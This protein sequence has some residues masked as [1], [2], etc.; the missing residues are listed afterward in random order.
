MTYVKACNVDSTFQEASDSLGHKSSQ[1]GIG[2]EIQRSSVFI[3]KL[4]PKKMGCVPKGQV[5]TVAIKKEENRD[6]RGTCAKF[7][8]ND[9]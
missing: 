4:H 8:W 7:D 5:R 6:D 2:H 1:V 9:P 3:T